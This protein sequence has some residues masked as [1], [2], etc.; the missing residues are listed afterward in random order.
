MPEDMGST[1]MADSRYTIICEFRGGTYASQVLAEDE[2]HAL[3]NWC[4]LV[5]AEKPIPRSSPYVA[6][7]V[8]RDIEK[9]ELEPQPL[10]G[11]VGVWC[12]SSSLDDDLILVNIVLSR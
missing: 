2:R 9:F 7:A 1:A 11:L 6:K 4:A 10:D 5:R 8:L 12:F 3:D